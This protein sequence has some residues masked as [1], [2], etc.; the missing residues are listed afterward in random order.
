MSCQVM[1][2]MEK[3]CD[4]LKIINLYLL[5]SELWA[6]EKAGREKIQLSSQ[7]WALS[8]QQKSKTKLKEQK[9]SWFIR[10]FLNEK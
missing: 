6:E 2:D 4:D 3:I 10:I 9:K 7:L 5:S 8:S 1:A